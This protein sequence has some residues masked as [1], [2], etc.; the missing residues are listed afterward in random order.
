MASLEYSA[1]ALSVKNRFHR[2]DNM[3]FVE[4]DDDVIFWEVIFEKFS[5]ATVRIESL[6]GKPEVVKVAEEVVKGRA[7]V[8]VALDSDF[9]HFVGRMEHDKML[10][11]FGY[12]IENTLLCSESLV[13]SIRS[14][15]CL[16]MSKIRIDDCKEWMEFSA[17]AVKPLVLH[18]IKNAESGFGVT[19]IGQNCSDLMKSKRSLDVCESLVEAR[20]SKLGFSI[21][22]TEAKRYLEIMRENESTLLDHLRGH[23]FFSLCWRFVTQICKKAKAKLT[24]SYDAFFAV[25][26]TWFSGHFGDAHPHYSH[27]ERIVL[28]VGC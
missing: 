20:L 16:P 12:S 21:D 15:G 17:E 18:D 7:A 24:L 5:E 1:E 23:F 2:V 22:E 6:G 13:Q 11:T 26:A 28:R 9:D 4:G 8:I 3:V 19:V 25:L 10:Y 14:V 27:Y